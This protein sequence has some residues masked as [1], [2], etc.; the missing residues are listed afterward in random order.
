MTPLQQ[1]H[2]AAHS[3]A[4]A[5]SGSPKELPPRD[6]TEESMQSFQARKKAWDRYHLIFHALCAFGNAC[7]DLARERNRPGKP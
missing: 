1:M 3:L 7:V 2:E 4:G 5:I 6:P